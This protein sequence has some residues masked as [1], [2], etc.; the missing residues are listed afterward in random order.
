MAFWQWMISHQQTGDYT[1]DR[2]KPF[3]SYNK[4]S[5]ANFLFQPYAGNTGQHLVIT[6]MAFMSWTSTKVG[7]SIFLCIMYREEIHNKHC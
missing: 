7:T 5:I 3:V 2:Y 1:Q 6:S 4:A